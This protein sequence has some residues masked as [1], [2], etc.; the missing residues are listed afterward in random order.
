[1]TIETIKWTNNKIRIID[2]RK[3]LVKLVMVLILAML[4]CPV[5]ASENIDS[6]YVIAYGR[7]IKPPYTI[8]IE[9]NTIFVNDM[10]YEPLPA[11]IKERENITVSEEAIKENNLVQLISKKYG[12][13]ATRYGIK[14]A[15]K[16][17]E[18]FLKKQEMIEAFKFK[19]EEV[20]IT[21]KGEGHR[22]I[23]ILLHTFRMKSS[24]APQEREVLGKKYMEASFKLLTELL[25]EGGLVAFGYGYK[26]LVPY[27]QSHE[28][29]SNIT[30]IISSEVSDI[31][32]EK[33]LIEVADDHRFVKDLLE[34]QTSWRKN[35]S[36]RYQ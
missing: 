3:R 31:E 12:D 7:Y 16:M 23:D 26:N 20:R 30:K 9:A 17:L 32:K 25:R 13:W 36:I 21:F 22:H 28:W 27:T 24:T 4:A 11:E 19:D 8:K 10:Q 5:Q 2:Q 6:G 35:T 15:L 1:M 29:V 14:K 33:L 34:N 18:E